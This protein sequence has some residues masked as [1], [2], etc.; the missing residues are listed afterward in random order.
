MLYARKISEDGWFGKEALDADSVSELGTKNHELSVWKVSDAKN[1]V[2]VDRVALALAL[3]LGKISEFYMVLLDPYDLQSRYKWAVAFAPQDG[4]TRYKKM[5][6]EHT[7]F[8]LDTFWEQ[9]Y[10]SEY[11]HQL[12]DDP[13]NYRYYDANSIKKMVYDA[14][15]AGDV[16]W[17]DIKFDGAWKKAIKEMEEVYGSLGL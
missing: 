8:V 9:G 10:L 6:G 15:K 11:I 13:N 7:N 16:E 17:E 14:L 4:D 1:N 2:D 12:I 5:K 3:T